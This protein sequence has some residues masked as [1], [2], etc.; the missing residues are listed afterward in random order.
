[1]KLLISLFILFFF[2]NS[3]SQKINL[4]ESHIENHFRN[5]QLLGEV[6]PSIT[7]TIRPISNEKNHFNYY[8]IIFKDSS[9]L[10]IKLLPVDAKNKLQFQHSF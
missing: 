3:F 1:M 4:N 6:D 10:K 8:K 2:Q 7:F 5:L 9:N